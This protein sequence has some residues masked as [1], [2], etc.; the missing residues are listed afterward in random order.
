MLRSALVVVTVML[1]G[2]A[3][4]GQFYPLSELKA[5]DP[6]DDAAEVLAHA[7]EVAPSQ[8]T[9]A[10]RGVVEQA[11][12]A[13]LKSMTVKDAD[14]AERALAALEEQRGRFGFLGTSPGWLS[15]RADVGVKALPWLAQSNSDGWV[16]QVTEFAAADA[17]TPKLAQR[18][19]TEVVL[20]R[21]IPSAAVPLF[22]LGFER[23]GEAMCA[24]DT[25]IKTAVELAASGTRWAAALDRCWKNLEGPMTEAVRTSDTRTAKLQLCEAMAPHASDAAVK[26]ACAGLEE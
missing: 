17:V 14:S 18:L 23:D 16:R 8:R 1:T 7:R 25:I 11:A 2:C 22:N 5:L 26:A 19:A 20:K 3:T 13:T 15:A 9:E 12:V 24:D 6:V 4:G 21:L 10:W